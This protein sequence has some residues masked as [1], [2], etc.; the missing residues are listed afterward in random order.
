M[1]VIPLLAVFAVITLAERMSQHMN[2]VVLIAVLVGAAIFMGPVVE[3]VVDKYSMRW[4]EYQNLR[5]ARRELRE[6]REEAEA[7]LKLVVD[8]ERGRR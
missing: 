6:A 5:R 3:I 2:I 8:S 4:D 1:S 7:A